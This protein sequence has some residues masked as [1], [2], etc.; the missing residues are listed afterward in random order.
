[1]SLRTLIVSFVAVVLVAACGGDSADTGSTS[2]TS[3][4]TPEPTTTIDTSAVPETVLGLVL[5]DASTRSGVPEDEL[6][7]V[8]AE[9]VEWPDGSLGCPEPG[10]MYTQAIVP[11]YRVEVDTPDGVLD[12]RTDSQ[13]NFRVC[14]IPSDD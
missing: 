9:Q 13:G 10:K 7:L 4:S 8:R 11:G 14:E 3:T 1:M 6:V 5:A 2:T 12:Y